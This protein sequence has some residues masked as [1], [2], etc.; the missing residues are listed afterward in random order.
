MK[1]E[2]GKGTA[3]RLPAIAPTRPAGPPPLV[4]TPAGQLPGAVVA[5]IDGREYWARLY[6]LSGTRYLR[7]IDVERAIH[8]DDPGSDV[9]AIFPEFEQILVFPVASDTMT[10]TA[11]AIARAVEAEGL[12]ATAVGVGTT[13]VPGVAT[14]E[15]PEHGR[16]IAVFQLSAARYAVT[17]LL[18][19]FVALSS[20]NSRWSYGRTFLGRCWCTPVRCMH[21][22]V[23]GDVADMFTAGLT[24][25]V[26]RGAP[27]EL[28]GRSRIPPF[29]IRIRPELSSPGNLIYVDV[30]WA[31]PP[32]P[33]GV[34]YAFRVDAD[35][36]G[37]ALHP[38][39]LCPELDLAATLAKRFPRVFGTALRLQ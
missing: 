6:S 28:D 16:V 18:P 27:D 25:R 11:H 17:E 13:A 15:D 10:A 29:D 21:M 5:E 38:R 32:A 3:R 4:L 39:G 34:S 9:Y 30:A 14:V 8:H 35:T 2:V 36:L 1:G 33:T 7:V 26:R 12:A 31:D 23:L 22:A 20:F 37:C 19:G 24:D